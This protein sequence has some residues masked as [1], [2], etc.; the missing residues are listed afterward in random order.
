MLIAGNITVVICV[1]LALLTVLSVISDTF[2]KKIKEGKRLSDERREPV[3]VIIIADNNARE[4]ERNLNIFLSQDYPV[5]YEV[6]VVIS[7]DED[8]TKDVLK[9]FNG[10][11]NLY[12]TFV[13]CTSRYMSVHKLAITLGVKAAKNE[14]ILLTDADCVPKTN[15]WIN[16]MAAHC[17]DDTGMVIGRCNYEEKASDYQRFYRLYKEYTFLYE[18]SNGKPYAMTGKNL[19]FKKSLFMKGQGFL[20]NLKYLRGEYAFLVNKYATEASATISL[21]SD[22]MLIE[23]APSQKEWHCENIFYAETRKHLAKGMRHRLIFN[24][25]MLSF[26]AAMFA[27][28]SLA[29]YSTVTVHWIILLFSAVS[30]I[31]PFVFRIINAKRAFRL[32]DV[33]LPVWKVIPFEAHLVWH[34]LKYLMKYKLADKYEFISHKS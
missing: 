29:F 12:V 4:L 21:S 7:K 15:L 19:L 26:Y 9:T 16:S 2:F 30:L 17:N 23:K 25:N 18:A 8:G 10:Y 32:F 13:P 20:G 14:M 27:S 5:G 24:M 6:I 1:V 3:S 31:C 28:M 11:K 33:K 22:G 34:N